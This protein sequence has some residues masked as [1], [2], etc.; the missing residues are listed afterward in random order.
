ME[1]SLAAIDWAV[2]LAYFALVG[3]VGLRV[4]GRQQ[5]T[6][7]YFLGGRSLPWWAA[8]LSIVATE[9]SAVTFIGVPA[10]A[11]SGD[12][13]LLQLVMGFV[14]GRLFLAFVFVA[15]FYRRDYLTVYGFLAQRFGERSRT[16]AA[17]FFLL[18]RLVASGVRLLAGCLA[19]Q[20]ATGLP[21]EV[22]ILALGAF[23]SLFTWV[24]GIRAVVWTDV[25]LGI[26]LVGGGVV[27][28]VWLLDGI[29]GGLSTVLS[30]PDLPTRTAI[31]HGGVSLT[32]GKS[33]LAGLVGGFVLTL[34]THGTDQDIAQRMLTCRSS[35]QGSMSVIGSAV[36]ILPLFALF[37]AVGTLLWYYHRLGAPSHEVPATLNQLLPRFIVEELPRG[38]AGLVMAGLLAAALSSF[39][40]ALNALAATSVGD[41]YRPLRERGGPVPEERLLAVSRVVTI[42]C[43]AALV[44]TALAFAGTEENIFD[45]A[46]KVFAYFY[47]ALLGPFLLG[48]L[49]RRGTDATVLGGMLISVPV[50]LVLQLR[51]FVESP[52]TSPG[53]IRGLIESMPPESRAAILARIPD[54]ASPY[55]LLAG[56]I[57]CMTVGAIRRSPPSRT[58]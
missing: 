44:L 50:V 55:W 31:V 22:A 28:A 49:T 13:S 21:L 14:L 40:S 12:W 4:A 33:L 25:I 53:A 7:D 56:T 29:P 36:L 43:G 35:R 1:S 18:G 54:L 2:V 19:V 10:A 23:G 51:E 57:V 46:I 41:I 11:F 37:L 38:L 48:I 9:T 30:D 8:S 47:A 6:R 52:T 26:T 5:S 45:L 39:T 17:V 58:G 27:A 42:A 15:V 16:T 20:A 34:A 24:G 32:D 3:A